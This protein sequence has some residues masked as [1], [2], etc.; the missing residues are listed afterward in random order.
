MRAEVS[1]ELM[2]RRGRK[3][4]VHDA[5]FKEEICKLV[6]GG[7]KQS[8]VAAKYE[9]DASQVSKWVRGRNAEGKEAFRGHGNRTEL[10]AENHR[11]KKEVQELKLEREIL[12]KAAA[13]FA[14]HQS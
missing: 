7:A 3:N 2:S 5:A 9:L 8:E 12:K 1:N 6:D 10:E 11:L 4:R 14:K 13:Y